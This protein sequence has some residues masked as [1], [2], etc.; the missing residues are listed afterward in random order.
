M[1]LK[2]KY[3]IAGKNCTYT[4]S[5]AKIATVNKKGVIYAKKTGK[6]TVKSIGA[7]GKVRVYKITVKKA[8]TKKTKVSL[9][10]KKVTLQAK[11]KKKTFQIKAKV[12]SKKFGSAAFKYTV[13]KKGKKVVKVSKTGKVTA[14]KKGK[15]VIT[16][17]TYNGKAKAVLK[18]T[19]K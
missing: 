8:P 15:A 18:V 14:K 11:G 16:V 1:G 2:E 10:K 5:N 19:V 13:D 7:D 3:S 12:S 17:K 9:N 6:A 4:I